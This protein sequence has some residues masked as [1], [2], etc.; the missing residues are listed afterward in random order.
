MPQRIH[1]QLVHRVPRP[2]RLLLVLLPLGHLHAAQ[3][4]RRVDVADLPPPR[5]LALE[6]DPRVRALEVGQPL[7]LLLLALRS[8]GETDRVLRRLVGVHRAAILV[9][10]AALGCFVQGLGTGVAGD[11]REELGGGGGCAAVV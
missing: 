11:G 5:H 10:C 6:V 2:L 1:P 9:C 4:V 7:I 3:V 8:S